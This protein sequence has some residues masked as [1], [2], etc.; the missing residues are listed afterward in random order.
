MGERSVTLIPAKKTTTNETNNEPKRLK[1]A[2]YCRISTDHEDIRKRSLK[3]LRMMV[4][5]E[6]AGIQ[7]GIHLRLSGF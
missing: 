4:F 6:A 5:S 2:A 7:N 1:M 3:D